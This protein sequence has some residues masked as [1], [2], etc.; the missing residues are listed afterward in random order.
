[1]VYPNPWKDQ[2]A[3]HI[4]SGLTQSGEVKLQV[5]TIV[6]RK[7]FE[8]TFPQ[9][10]AG[11]EVTWNGTDNGGSSLSNGIYYV[12]VTSNGQKSVSKLLVLK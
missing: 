7:V 5:F 8:R 9:V 3:I 4:T 10:P 12:V 6:F 11:G 2:G 1:M